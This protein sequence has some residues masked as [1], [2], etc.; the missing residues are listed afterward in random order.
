MVK[1]RNLSNKRKDLLKSFNK[2]VEKNNKKKF[3]IGTIIVSLLSIPCVEYFQSK[4]AFAFSNST[5]KSLEINKESKNVNTIT[6]YEK[7]EKGQDIKILFLGDENYIGNTV[8]KENINNFIK[9]TY[10]SDVNLTDLS[11]TGGSIYDQLNEYINLENRYFDLVFLCFENGDEGEIRKT[12]F[13]GIYETILRDL[14]YNNTSVDIIPVI[15]H[16]TLVSDTYYQIINSISKYY[17]LELAKVNEEVLNNNL[18]GENIEDF[19][20]SYYSVLS[21][22]ISNNV[23]NKKEI[24]TEYK[25]IY[26]GVTTLFEPYKVTVKPEKKKGFST[27]QNQAKS[28]N[29]DD[30]IRYKV[31]GNTVGLAYETSENGGIIEVYINRVLYRRVDTKSDKKEIKH[32]LV[33]SD[34]T[35]SNE[36]KVVNSS[37]GDVTLLGVITSG[38][39]ENSSEVES[40]N[41]IL[42]RNKGNYN[43]QTKD[44]ALYENAKIDNNEE[45]ATSEKS[46]SVNKTSSKTQNY[47]KKPNVINKTPIKEN[48]PSNGI[49]ENQEIINNTGGN[50]ESNLEENPIQSGG[51]GIN[52]STNSQ[53]N[54]GG[55]NVNNEINNQVSSGGESINN[56]N[57]QIN[58][59]NGENLENN[60]T[61]NNNVANNP[62]IGGVENTVGNEIQSN[63]IDTNDMQ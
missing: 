14:K 32:I 28:S 45:V 47:K 24:N 59:N 50:S 38:N 15:K 57:N 10:N 7:L 60:N 1:R 51:D 61:T 36:V 34:L 3:I 54:N 31:E 44:N 17:D 20:D 42:A 23:D 53:V 6:A 52:N 35:K 13:S 11:K 62:N 5:F 33:S 18:Q 22:I 55:D 2:L 58:N 25:D 19:K 8:L 21:N 48:I 63:I 27:S 41:K 26:Y 40:L 16:K 43:G 37:G 56:S 29:K 49:K 30:Y 12:S 46:E 4:N 39:N 9:E